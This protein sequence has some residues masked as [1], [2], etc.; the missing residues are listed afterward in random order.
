MGFDVARGREVPGTSGPALY[1]STCLRRVSRSTVIA[2]SRASR[3]LLRRRSSWS[4]A[5]AW[6]GV[7]GR[8]ALGGGSAGSV[9]CRR[10]LERDGVGVGVLALDVTSRGER[11]SR[12]LRPVGIVSGSTTGLV[13]CMGRVFDAPML[14]RA[15]ATV[16]SP[17]EDPVAECDN[18]MV[19]L[20]GDESSECKLWLVL[21]VMRLAGERWPSLLPR[22]TDI[23]SGIRRLLRC[24]STELHGVEPVLTSEVGEVG[25]L[26]LLD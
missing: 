25:G 1:A 18:E 20:A 10:E 8:G 9:F 23:L 26:V 13:H 24:R 19:G 16:S 6:F 5:I 4:A 12:L 21:I 17:S 14:A 3:S 7:S 15:S 2:L 11:P 22:L